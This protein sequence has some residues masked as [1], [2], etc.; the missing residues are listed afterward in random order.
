MRGVLVDDDQP[1]AG[2]RH[3]I[4]FVHL[5]ARRPERALDL[6]GRRLEALGAGVG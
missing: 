6:L 3:D 5:G 4:S 2:L 1:V